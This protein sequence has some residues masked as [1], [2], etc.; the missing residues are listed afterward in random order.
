MTVLEENL[1]GLFFGDVWYLGILIFIILTLIIIKLWKYAGALIIPFVVAI[2][3]QY[4]T[5]LDDNP[6]FAWAMIALLFLVIGVAVY[7]VT[8]KE[9]R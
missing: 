3:V 5:R 6:E 1:I 8:T 9:K 7:I 4:Y 2:E